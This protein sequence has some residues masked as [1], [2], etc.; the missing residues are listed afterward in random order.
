MTTNSTNS[1]QLNSTQLNQL[2]DAMT[3]IPQQGD[4]VRWSEQIHDGTFEVELRGWR[5]D[6]GNWH[7]DDPGRH[8]R[9]EKVP[10]LPPIPERWI[11]V[12]ANGVF[13]ESLP[14]HR[15]A[16]STARRYNYIGILHVMPSGSCEMLAVEP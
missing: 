8:G 15:E 6:N 10:D 5:D 1:T 16:R 3:Y 4:T 14:T 11:C 13:G 9:W 2:Q 7:P 12:S